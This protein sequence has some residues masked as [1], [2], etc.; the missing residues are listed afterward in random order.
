MALGKTGRW[1]IQNVLSE[2][3]GG[4]EGEE[5]RAKWQGHWCVCS[6]GSTRDTEP[7][8]DILEE[9]CCKKLIYMILKSDWASLESMEQAMWKGEGSGT[10]AEAA[11]H[12]RV[13]F[14]A[15]LLL[16]PFI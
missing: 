1:D 11:V 2:W 8:R 16:V 14:S 10:R 9:I 4:G 13:S 12:S 15:F 7:V 6:Q 5:R 3:N